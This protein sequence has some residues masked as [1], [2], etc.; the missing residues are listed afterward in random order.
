M[1]ARADLI[2]AVLARPR[3]RPVLAHELRG[4]LVQLV[5]AASTVPEYQAPP[6]LL[7]QTIDQALTRAEEKDT[8]APPPPAPAGA[9]PRAAGAGT[10][11][12]PHAL[13]I[14][15]DRVDLYGACTCGHTLG[16]T[17]RARRT[18]GLV[19][20]WEQHLRDHLAEADAAWAN[21]L[22]TL[23]PSNGAS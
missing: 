17:P 23:T 8:P 16:R 4:P 13:V 1:T 21:A 10:A 2:A 14:T 5:G 20:L 3:L 12:T 6:A 18:D 11:D 19:G 22:T 15:A 7:A 9:G